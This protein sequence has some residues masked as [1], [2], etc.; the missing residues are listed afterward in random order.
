VSVSVQSV[1][2]PGTLLKEAITWGDLLCR[3]AF[4]HEG[5][6]S[7]VGR[8]PE[9]S[10]QEGPVFSGVSALGPDMYAGTA[11]VAVFLAQLYRA[12]GHPVYRDTAMGAIRHARRGTEALEPKSSLGLHTGLSGIA[13]ALVTTGQVIGE[14]PL[15]SEGAELAQAV[16][17]DRREAPLL[18]FI[19]GA[20]SAICVLLALHR[21]LGDERLRQTAD[22]LGQ[23]LIRRGTRQNA[24]WTWSNADLSG[25]P[26]WPRMLNGLAH[27]ASGVAIALLELYA[28]TGRDEYREAGL[29]AFAHEDQFIDSEQG[30]WQDLRNDTQEGPGDR[31]GHTIAWCHGAPGIC[32]ARL[33]AIQLMPELS[34]EL[35]SSIAVALRGTEAHATSQLKGG[36]FDVTSC[37]G[38]AGLTE[39]FVMGSAVL[40]DPSLL[41]QAQ[42]FWIEAIRRRDEKA[43]WLS[44]VGSGG[45]NH[46]LMLGISG[47]GYGLLR[48]YDPQGTPSILLPY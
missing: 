10:P 38:L 11:G 24:L 36:A 34:A 13:F 30:N 28:A 21:S 46:S 32:L 19:A 42:K 6:C 29:G 7:W 14:P 33:R 3:E 27:G 31:S 26:Q 4:W 35:R 25:A 22:T 20:S 47:V 9:E 37:H 16:V 45:K 43:T 17:S 23:E 40:D 39:P 18:D 15:V 1:A 8:S 44:G 48:A 5:R 12:T 41:L 2:A